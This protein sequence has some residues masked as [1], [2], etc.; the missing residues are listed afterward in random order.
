MHPSRERVSE[1]EIVSQSVRVAYTARGAAAA[2]KQAKG[3]A[4][5]GSILYTAAFP[6]EMYRTPPQQQ[7]RVYWSPPTS[8]SLSLTHRQGG[9][10]V[11]AFDAGRS[12]LSPRSPPKGPGVRPWALP[13]PS[14][15]WRQQLAPF[16]AP[17][18]AGCNNVLRQPRGHRRDRLRF[19]RAPHVGLS[20]KSILKRV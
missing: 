13:G 4:L 14:A 11:R 10:G 3:R 17:F 1:R 9:L 15:R 5:F 16:G 20:K 6:S 18:L 7:S 19:W 2:A 8:L 12:P